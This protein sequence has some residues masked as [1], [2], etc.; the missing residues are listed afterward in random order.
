MSGQDDVQVEWADGWDSE[1]LR[2]TVS[3]PGWEVGFKWSSRHVEPKLGLVV[4]RAIQGPV[5][6]CSPTAVHV[7]M[8]PDYARNGWV[9]PTK[10]AGLPGVWLTFVAV[11]RAEC[12]HEVRFSEKW[13]GR[14]LRIVAVIKS[15]RMPPSHSRSE[16]LEALG[17][18]NTEG[19][20]Q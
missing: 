6:P 18:R 13:V 2:D 4:D 10:E 8:D 16:F 14:R 19:M 7:A 17:V 5:K 20:T 11:M 12:T 9:W 1:R 15:R 3:K